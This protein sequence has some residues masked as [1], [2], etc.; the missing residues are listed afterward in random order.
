M[1]IAER[2]R[3]V[4]EW[5][6]ESVVYGKA[7]AC[8]DGADEIERLTRERDEAR[9]KAALSL[10]W[11]RVCGLELVSDGDG[12]MYCRCCKAVERVTALEAAF[13]AVLDVHRRPW[14]HGMDIH[15]TDTVAYAAFRQRLDAVLALGGGK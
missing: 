15:I 4:A 1:N 10:S 5:C 6:R 14:D 3:E 2:L 13:V 9:E 11:C 8:D 7:M 12:V